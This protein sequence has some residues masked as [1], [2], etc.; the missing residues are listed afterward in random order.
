MLQDVARRL[1]DFVIAQNLEA[2]A[3]GL[4]LLRP[5]VIKLLGQ[6]AL[7]E[8]RVSLGLAATKDVDVF[9]DYEFSV[10]R[11]FRRLLAGEGLELD[12]LGR[13]I[14]MPAETKYEPLF[15]GRFVTL[16]VAD[17]DAVLLSKGLKAPR[18]NGPLLTEYLARGAS[19]RFL[20]LARKYGLD[21]E[22]FV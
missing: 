16:L 2:R 10:E 17:A 8:S 1:D 5:C 18:K 7:M 4:P 20:K 13:E 6:R 15:K 11:E 22:Q 14:W 3:E 9:A 21:L 12:P 19:P